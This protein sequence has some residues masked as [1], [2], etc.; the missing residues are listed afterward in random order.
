IR[1]DC[2]FRNREKVEKT[3]SNMGFR[4]TSY[5]KKL[6]YICNIVYK[7]GSDCREENMNEYILVYSDKEKFIDDYRKIKARFLRTYIS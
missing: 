1:I 4:E 2:R 6:G 3:L 7:K 5:I